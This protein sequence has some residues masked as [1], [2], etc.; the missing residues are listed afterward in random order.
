MAFIGLLM[1]IKSVCTKRDAPTV[2]YYCGQTEGFDGFYA[3]S[4][5]DYA[6]NLSALPLLQCLR[7]PEGW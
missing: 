7:P 3:E 5:A 6:R 4:L 2:A 1:W